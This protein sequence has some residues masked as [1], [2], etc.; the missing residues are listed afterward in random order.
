MREVVV[1]FVVL[2]TLH[3][4]RPFP[5]CCTA[6]KICQSVVRV[7]SKRNQINSGFV[8]RFA[9][10]S[11]VMKSA[12][13]DWEDLRL[14]SFCCASLGTRCFGG[15]KIKLAGSRSNSFL[16]ELACLLQGP[17]STSSAKAEAI[18]CR[19]AA[20]ATLRFKSIWDAC[21]LVPVRCNGY[22]DKNALRLAVVVEAH[23]LSLDI[24]VST[25]KCVSCSLHSF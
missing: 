19:R 11:L 18:E 16:T 9:E 14:S 23:Q 6:C 22:V 12:G 25:L 13:D 2:A 21:R 7:G 4:P 10:W 17:L 24:F 3:A 20:R 15:C 5:C 1:S 8:A